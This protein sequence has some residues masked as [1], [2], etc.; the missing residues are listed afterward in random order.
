MMR[1]CVVC[2]KEFVPHAIKKTCSPECSAIYEKIYRKKYYAEHDG[3]TR[4]RRRKDPLPPVGCAYC[5]KVFTPTHGHQRYCSKECSYRQYLARQREANVERLTLKCVYCGHEFLAQ[6]TTRKYCS[7]KC[8]T[9]FS[10]E[11]YRET[12]MRYDRERRRLGKTDYT[13]YSDEKLVGAAGSCGN[14]LVGLSSRT[15]E[16]VRGVLDEM[17]NL[18]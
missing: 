17:L 8:R 1:S 10:R 2:G 3:L 11:H 18:N 14:C 5:G 15:V 9:A 4:S 16:A 13:R 6:R 7:V 12:R